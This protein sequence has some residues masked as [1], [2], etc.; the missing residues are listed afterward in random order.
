M[1]WEKIPEDKP[2]QPGD[3]VRLTFSAPG[4]FFF[5]AMEAAMIE[6]S[7]ANKEGYRL[8]SIDYM[9][10]G[11]MI[12]KLRIVKTNP[13]VVTV[14]VI[15]A[16]IMIVGYAVGLMFESAEQFVEAIKDLV[17]PAGVIAIVGMVL[18]MVLRK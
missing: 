18:Y 3:T 17:V 10:P 2:L 9:T 5:K 12:F 8:T 4:P 15:T 7:L 6:S 13:F 11:K 1:A 16:G 14:L